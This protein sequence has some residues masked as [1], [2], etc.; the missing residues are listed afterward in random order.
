MKFLDYYSLTSHKTGTELSLKEVQLISV[1][2]LQRFDQLCLDYN[3]NYTLAGGSLIGAIRHHGYIPWDDDI[4]IFILRP[5]FD[6]L[7]KCIKREQTEIKETFMFAP[8]LDNCYLPYGQ[9]CDMKYTTVLEY[10]PRVKGGSGM[11]IDVFPIEGCE[12]DF[13]SFE[14]RLKMINRL[15]KRYYQIRGTKMPIT[16]SLGFIRIIKAIGK[17]LFYGHYNIDEEL[18]HLTDIMSEIEIRQEGFCSNL[19]CP[20]Y[21]NKEFYPVSDFMEFTRKPFEN[22]EVS[23]IKDY[24]DYLTR[25]YGDYMKLPPLN[26]QIPKHDVNKVYWK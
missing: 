8:E 18:K 10:C 12:T 22:I 3:I 20:T 24:D 19:H 1:Y 21:N 4:D 23:V 13:N 14:Q 2:L 9:F 25:V 26:E 11:W 5:E 15:L 16:S 7:I 17:R 6:K